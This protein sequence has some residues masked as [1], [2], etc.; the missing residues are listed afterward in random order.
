MGPAQSWT[1]CGLALSAAL[2][3]VSVL[4]SIPPLRVFVSAPPRP[5][6]ILVVSVVAIVFWLSRVALVRYWVQD[7]D[8]NDVRSLFRRRERATKD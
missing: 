7:I 1:W 5:L 3:L 6:P 2:V 4:F 8:T